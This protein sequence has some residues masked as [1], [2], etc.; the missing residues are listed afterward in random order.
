M[1]K[2]NLN[3]R[4][5]QTQNPSPQN[6]ITITLNINRFSHSVSAEIEKNWN[7]LRSIANKWNKENRKIAGMYSSTPSKNNNERTEPRYNLSVF[8]L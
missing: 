3:C 8:P 2:M 6:S 5:T 7:L 1:T 4:Q